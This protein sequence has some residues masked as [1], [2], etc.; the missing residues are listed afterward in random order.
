MIDVACIVFN[1]YIF[2]NISLNTNNIYILLLLKKGAQL[3]YFERYIIYTS[4]IVKIL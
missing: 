1:L 2:I 3:Y 4:T